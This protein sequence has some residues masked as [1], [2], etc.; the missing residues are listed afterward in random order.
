MPRQ[1][2]DA[3]GTCLEDSPRTKC[4]YAGKLYSRILAVDR[5]VSIP[6]DRGSRLGRWQLRAQRLSRPRR[7]WQPRSKR[8]PMA[9]D[10]GPR[11]ADGQDESDGS[12][13]PDVGSQS[14]ATENSDNEPLEGEPK[15]I[16]EAMLQRCLLPDERT[17][18]DGDSDDSDEDGG[19]DGGSE[20]SEGDPLAVTGSDAEDREE[21]A[22]LQVHV[23]SLREG[24]NSFDDWSRCAWCSHLLARPFFAPTTR[25][26]RLAHRVRSTRGSQGLLPRG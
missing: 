24:I 5:S 20:A 15:E 9:S 8:T 16:V 18:G 14:T 17:L 1:P 26:T 13:S 2:R 10:P 19:S 6:Q 25:L 4:R 12:L 11:F 3:T 22:A 21:S 23:C 7:V